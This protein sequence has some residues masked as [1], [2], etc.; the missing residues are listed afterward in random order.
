MNVTTEV[1]EYER[2]THET[3]GTEY[4]TPYIFLFYFIQMEKHPKIREEK[5][6]TPQMPTIVAILAT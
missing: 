3:L 1:W 4:F 2:D 6:W 5:M